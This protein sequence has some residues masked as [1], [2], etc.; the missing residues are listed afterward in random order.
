MFWTIAVILTVLWVLGMASGATL[1]MWVHVLL[2]FALISVVLA[3]AQRGRPA[4]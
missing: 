1:G 2:V 4:F 3:V